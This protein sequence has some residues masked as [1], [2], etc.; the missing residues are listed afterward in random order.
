MSDCL[1]C[2][3]AAGDIPADKVV[4]GERVLAFRD[5]HPQA[6]THVLVIPRKHISTTLEAGE[7]DREVLGELVTTAA[8]IALRA[9]AG[10]SR[11]IPT[12]PTP[13]CG[14]GRWWDCLCCGALSTTAR[15]S[16]T[17]CVIGFSQ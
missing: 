5:I 7:E 12:T 8:G 10:S 16:A 13:S 14:A 9:A 2:K 17:V 6:P 15:A 1:F 4:D 11:S 3:I